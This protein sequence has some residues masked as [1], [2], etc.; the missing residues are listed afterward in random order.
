MFDTPA[1][2][3]QFHEFNRLLVS[4]TDSETLIL[5]TAILEHLGDAATAS[6][7]RFPHRDDAKLTRRAQRSRYV[8]TDLSEAGD[9]EAAEQPLEQTSHGAG[10]VLE[11]GQSRSVIDILTSSHGQRFGMAQ[12]PVTARSTDVPQ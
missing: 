6:Y 1:W 10:Q 5:L 11:S 9:A 2:T 7:T 12:R 4:M 8:L 3:T